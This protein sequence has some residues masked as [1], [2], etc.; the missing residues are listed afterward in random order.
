MMRALILFWE[1]CTLHACSSGCLVVVKAFQITI[2]QTLKTGSYNA[3]L[4]RKTCLVV[5]GDRFSAGGLLAQLRRIWVQQL[6]NGIK[7]CL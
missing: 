4:K 1:A 7:V 3:L 5:Q 2:H 6:A